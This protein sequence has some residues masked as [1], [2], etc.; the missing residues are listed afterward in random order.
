M[1]LPPFT[2]TNPALLIIDVQQAIDYFDTGSRNNPDAELRMAELLD[3]WRQQNKPVVHIRHSSKSSDSP[4]HA[5]SPF[6]DF[7]MEVAPMAGEKVVSKS[8]NC[9]FID[10][11][12]DAYLKR[13]QVTELVICGVLTNN[14][15]DATVRVAAGLGYRIYLP[16]DATAAFPL[17]ALN[18]KQFSA[19]DVHWI[20]LSNLHDEY[21]NVVETASIL[22]GF[23]D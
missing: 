15:V 17:Q 2:S 5:D 8:E 12:L 14:S 6:F 18:G 3:R 7:K 21:A 22:S 20:F 9:A 13:E 11:Q 16:Q 1:N 23:P 4:Y 10:P 19:E